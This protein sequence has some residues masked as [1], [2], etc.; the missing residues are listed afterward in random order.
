MYF[1]INGPLKS[2][3]HHGGASDAGSYVIEQDV[4]R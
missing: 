3:L 2:I 1:V 4:I